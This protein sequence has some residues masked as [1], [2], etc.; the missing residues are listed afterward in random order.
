MIQIGCDFFM[1]SK[2]RWYLVRRQVRPGT[3]GSQRQAPRQWK[4][5]TILSPSADYHPSMRSPSPPPRRTWKED[6]GPSRGVQSPS[7]PPSQP[8]YFYSAP[9]YPPPLKIPLLGSRIQPPTPCPLWGVPFVGDHFHLIGYT[10]TCRCFL[11]RL[12]A[13]RLFFPVWKPNSACDLCECHRLLGL[14]TSPLAS[15]IT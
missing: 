4:S 7:P 11:V 15:G 12:S 14:P 1:S 2:R 9:Q 10:R 3:A 13:P 8:S 5:P 6:A